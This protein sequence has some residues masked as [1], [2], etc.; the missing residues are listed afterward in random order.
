[1]DRTPDAELVRLAKQFREYAIARR[2]AAIREVNDLSAMLGLPRY[3]KD[4]RKGVD[5]NKE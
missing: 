1:M 4:D 3:V 5:V 2:R